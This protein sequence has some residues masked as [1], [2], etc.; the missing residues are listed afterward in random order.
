MAFQ[1]LDG[2]LFNESVVHEAHHDIES[3]VWVMCYSICRQLLTF[4]SL[5]KDKKKELTSFFHN[6]FG[7]V[8]LNTIRSSRGVRAP[9]E[10]RRRFA[11][12]LSSPLVFLLKRLDG[13]VQRHHL[14]ESPVLLT[15]EM[16]LVEFDN[17]IGE[18]Q[19]L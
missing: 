13:H 3:F 16:I 11:E 9:L 7:R 1:I 14:T 19:K 5:T 17:T 15:H 18:L 2:I 10:I 4:K 6:T 8:D 12:S